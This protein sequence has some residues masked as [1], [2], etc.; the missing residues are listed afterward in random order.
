MTNQPKYQWIAFFS[1]LLLVVFVLSFSVNADETGSEKKAAPAYVPGELLIR[2]KAGTGAKYI[3][4][5]HSKMGI[6]KSGD[7]RTLT[8]KKKPISLV[9]IQDD[10]Q[11][12]EVVLKYRADPAVEY[13]QPNY[14][15][16][17]RSSPNDPLLPEVWGLHNTGQTV[18]GITGTEDADVDA[19]EAWEVTTGSS[20]VVVALIDSGVAYDHP[21]LFDNIWI[22]TGETADDG[23]D[24]DGNGYLDDTFGWDF[25]DDDNDP[26]DESY[27]SHG[28]CIA[29]IIGATGN[30]G[31]GIS[32][33]N[34]HTHIMALK[35][36]G[37]G[38]GFGTTF[39]ISNAIDYSIDNGAHIINASWG[40]DDLNDQLLYDAI[41]AAGEAGL[42]FVS[43]T[44]NA[45]TNNDIYPSY[46]DG[47]DLPNILSVTAS[48][49]FDY[50]ASAGIAGA[51]FSSNFGFNS[52]DVAAPGVNIRST[53]I[54]DYDFLS[55]TSI[56]AAFV[57]GVA[58]L[59]LSEDSELTVSMIK[60]VILASVDQKPELN[61]LLV[62]G[63]RINAYKALCFLSSIGCNPQEFRFTAT[64]GAGNP[65]AQALNIWN[66]GKGILNWV[67]SSDAD[68]LSLDPAQGSSRGE[69]QPVQITP[70]ISDLETG[71]YHATLTIRS[72]D[73]TD[74]Y[75]SLS[76][77][78]TINSPPPPAGGSKSS[79]CFINSLPFVGKQ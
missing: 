18:K 75:Q 27:N 22:N 40:G 60:D 78:L 56:A 72:T 58:G 1:I 73:S 38:G 43:A 39:T 46:P 2:F 13:A 66:S 34:W 12:M 19:P 67:A 25:F 6:K 28:T 61:T 52:V 51:N 47:Y 32:G 64:K 70:A 48:D 7:V 54:N 49:Q 74:T 30:N 77:N 50:L 23:I 45:G 36:S 16:P 71:N 20:D 62:T 3:Q 35:I 31:I 41:E 17:F 59:L 10:L 37:A 11:V 15:Y 69:T 29:G 57:S 21:D 68:W 8:R 33:L 9:K 53:S 76:V 55:G 65:P 63:G 42:L 4:S 44:G 24:N 5:V 79:G 26:M 14:V